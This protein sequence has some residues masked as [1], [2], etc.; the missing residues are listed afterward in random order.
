MKLLRH[1]ANNHAIDYVGY[2]SLHYAAQYGQAQSIPLLVARGGV[3]LDAIS[4]HGMLE[5]PLFAI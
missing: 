2:T 5:I 4:I 1:G 3:T